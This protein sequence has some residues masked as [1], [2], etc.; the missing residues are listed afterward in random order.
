MRQR[1]ATV[2]ARSEVQALTQRIDRL[3]S[4]FAITSRSLVRAKYAVLDRLYQQTLQGRI[5][6]CLI[7]GYQ[8]PR[9]AYATRVSDCQFGG[10]AL[11]RYECPQCGAL[12][13]PMKVLD[14]PNDELMDEYRLLYATYAEADPTERELRTFH[15]LAPRKE[16]RY[17]NWG[18]GADTKT[19]GL[20]R[21]AGWDV[22][23]YEPAAPQTANFILRDRGAL[24]EKF[25]GIF[26][27]NVIEHFTQPVEQFKEFGELLKP[28]AA[29]AHATPCYEYLYH[30]TRFHTI[31]YL[32]KSLDT[33]IQKTGFRIE[34]R[35][36]EGD[37]MNVV[38]RH[39]A[40]GD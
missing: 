23:G 14:L 11:E 21:A 18:C 15:S 30:N 10:G 22:W 28:R 34:S 26:S 13:G 9:E 37:Y 5:L 31:F 33:L 20:L 24:S 19:V 38:F 4:L 29:M 7:C 27:N 36:A 1:Q 25:D 17:L 35:Q 2:A 3:E 12:F 39:V 8:A 32:G 16:G 40:P 6:T